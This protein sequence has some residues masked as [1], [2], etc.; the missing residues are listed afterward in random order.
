MQPFH[1]AFLPNATRT[2]SEV[3]VIE[4]SATAPLNPA[5][6]LAKPTSPAHIHALRRI[7]AL[8]LPIAYPEKF[9]TDLLPA[10][11]TGKIDTARKETVERDGAFPADPT[12]LAFLAFW[13]SPTIVLEKETSRTTSSDGKVIGGVRCRLELDPVPVTGLPQSWTSTTLAKRLYIS[14]ISL[15]SPYRGLGVA[16]GLLE[17]AIKEGLRNDGV[18][19]VYAHVWQGNESVLEWY[20]KRGFVKGDMVQH[21]YRRLKPDGAWV[22]WKNVGISEGM[23]GYKDH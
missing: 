14:T 8:F 4:D 20:E 10:A 6:V 11:P 13:S 19:L 9:Y 2:A 23:D 21:Y 16:T 22:V 3:E 12:A 18:R 7:N 17:K 1:S 5:V 15:L